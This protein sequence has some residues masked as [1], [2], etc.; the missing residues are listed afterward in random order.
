M[1]SFAT[2]FLTTGRR[3]AIA[4]GGG[5]VAPQARPIGKTDAAPVTGAPAP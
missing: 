4:G 3:V 5:Q 1:Q 2:S